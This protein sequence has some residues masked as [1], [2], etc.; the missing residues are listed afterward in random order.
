MNNSQS[1]IDIVDLLYNTPET[2]GDRITG[3]NYKTINI[4]GGNSNIS[5][6]KKNNNITGGRD[7]DKNNK[8]IILIDTKFNN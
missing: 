6:S 4:E 8:R 5:K 3:V 7:R 1:G 2:S